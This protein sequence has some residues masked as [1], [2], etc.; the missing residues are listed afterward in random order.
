MIMLYLE[1]TNVTVFCTSWKEVINKDWG[2]GQKMTMST[3]WKDEKLYF[4]KTWMKSIGLFI[5]P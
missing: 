1:N 4:V 3:V 5:N 2:G